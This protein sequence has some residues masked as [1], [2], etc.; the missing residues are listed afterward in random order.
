MMRRVVVQLLQIVGT[1][2]RVADARVIRRGRGG[3][4]VRM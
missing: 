2:N 1:V 3:I 4:R